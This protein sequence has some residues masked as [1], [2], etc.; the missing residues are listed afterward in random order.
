MDPDAILA[1]IRTAIDELNFATADD[2]HA[3]LAQQIGDLDTWITSGGFLPAAW[4]PDTRDE[5][6]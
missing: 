4:S 1:A 5:E 6:G 2:A 3:A